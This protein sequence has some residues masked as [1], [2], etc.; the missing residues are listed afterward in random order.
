MTTR[1][2]IL[3]WFAACVAA[4]GGVVSP[5]GESADGGTSPDGASADTGSGACTSD[6]SCPDDEWCYFSEGTCHEPGAAGTC[7]ERVAAPCV[8]PDPG[9]GDAVCGCDGMTYES[10]CVATSSSMS[11]LHDGAC[12]GAPPTACGG[13]DLPPCPS[14]SYCDFGDGH[15]TELGAV[16]TC[17]AKPIGCP[18][19]YSPVCGCDGVTYGNDCE[20]HAAGTNY[21]ATGECAPSTSKSCGGFAGA[22]CDA[23]EYCDWGTLP[24]DCGGAD[25]SG[26]CKPRPTSCPPEHGIFCGCDGKVY[27][28]PCDAALAGQGVRNEGPC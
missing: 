21:G 24:S 11:I 4:C 12:D 25:G 19:N 10:A 27:D 15:C 5:S 16:G 9:G 26:T 22:T 8:A 18:K 14:G 28:S 20:A 2:L 3:S 6:A 23:D 7:R 13:T 1:F 17:V